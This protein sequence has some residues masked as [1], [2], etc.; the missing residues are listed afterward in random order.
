MSAST[1][2]IV[3]VTEGS[4]PNPLAWL[5][6][7]AEVVQAAPGDAG[8]E[9][10][11]AKC[12]G[13]M[14]RTYTRV[15]DALL[16]RAPHLKVIGRGGVGLDNIDIPACRRRGIE[17]VYTPDANTLAV[18]DYIF[19]VMIRLVRGW[20]LIEK[21]Y[22]PESFKK[23]RNAVRGRQLDEMTLGILGLGRVGK[24]VG[25]IAANGFGMRVIYNDLVQMTK[26]SF[27]AQAVDKQSLFR[28]CDVLT[29]HVDMR[30]GNEKLVGAQQIGLMKKGSILINASRGEVLD[31]GAVAEAIRSGQLAGAALD[32]Y[33]P[34]PPAA[35]LELI[36]MPNV[37]LTPHIASRTHT[38][39]ENMGW[40]VRDVMNV[41]EKRPAEFPAP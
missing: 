40:V 8:F 14:V 27:A 18:G 16:T 15:N 39:V 25:A 11:L 26:L 37:I 13:L 10:A 2:P 22:A 21:G 34:E 5:R 32:V 3:L 12:Q 1:R 23:T 33:D 31:A 4:D 6:E 30:S 29:I 41:I 28:E 20:P 35:E 19:G 7:R 17:V 24:R 9:E 38:A 36:G